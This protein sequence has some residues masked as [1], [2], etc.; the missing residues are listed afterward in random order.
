MGAQYVFPDMD[1]PAVKAVIPES[2]RILANQ[3]SLMLTNV[4]L[5]VLL[6]PFR[7]IKTIHVGEELV[8]AFRA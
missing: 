8:W 2:G 3:P 4:S 5:A 6:V 7:I 1:G